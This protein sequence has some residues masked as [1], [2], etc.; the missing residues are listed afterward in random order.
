MMWLKHA[1]RAGLKKAEDEKL[2]EGRR[3]WQIPANS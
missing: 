2:R 3:R 1:R